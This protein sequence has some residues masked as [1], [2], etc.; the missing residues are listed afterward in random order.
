MPSSW[1]LVS[2]ALVYARELSRHD[3]TLATLSQWDDG[4]RQGQGNAVSVRG[5][6]DQYRE[7]IVFPCGLHPFKSPSHAFLSN[8]TAALKLE[9]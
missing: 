5:G 9:A 3:V 6:I 1:D 7:N 8:D 2:Y 4:V